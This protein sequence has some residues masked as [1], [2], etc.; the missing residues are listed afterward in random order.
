MATTVRVAASMMMRFGLHGFV[1]LHAPPL[2]VTLPLLFQRLAELAYRF[3]VGSYHTWS[4][5]PA[6]SVARMVPLV[7]FRMSTV[8]KSPRPPGR[9]PTAR[10]VPGPKASPVGSQAGSGN[11]F[12]AEPKELMVILAPAARGAALNG[13]IKLAG[14][15]STCPRGWAVVATLLTR[16]L[17]VPES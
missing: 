7:R 16:K 8:S 6:L 17:C 2:T 4:P 5:P 14:M 13:V 12:T 3:E 1:A 15:T 10:S 9:Q 11:R